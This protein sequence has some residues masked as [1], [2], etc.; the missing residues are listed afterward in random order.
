MS[1]THD[2]GNYYWHTMTARTRRLLQPSETVEIEP[3]FREGRC[4]LL[5]LPW[6][7]LCLVVGR[8]TGAQHEE[9]A[10]MQALGARAIPL[11]EAV[12]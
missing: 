10:L 5:R 3:P 2:I 8:W 6:T 9:D 1:Q 4:L 7:R 12:K 11:R